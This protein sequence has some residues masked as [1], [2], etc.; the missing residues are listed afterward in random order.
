M[1]GRMVHNRLKKE[2]GAL[3]FERNTAKQNRGQVGTVFDVLF[4]GERG[5]EREREGERARWKGGKV[6][7]VGRRLKREGERERDRERTVMNL[8]VKEVRLKS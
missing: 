7:K 6:L 1:S 8:F 5:R 2:R 3:V 4:K